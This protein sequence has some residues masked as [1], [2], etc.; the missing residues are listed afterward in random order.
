MY[1]RSSG[2]QSPAE[3]AHECVLQ[4]PAEG[5]RSIRDGLGYC[6]V[7][8]LEVKG[9]E[10]S[11]QSN[12]QGRQQHYAQIVIEITMWLVAVIATRALHTAATD[13]PVIVIKST[14]E[15]FRGTCR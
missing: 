15:P 7:F 3:F 8:T 11:I 1:T 6:L 13:F 12:E 5:R 10:E 9:H 14:L 4:P 2:E